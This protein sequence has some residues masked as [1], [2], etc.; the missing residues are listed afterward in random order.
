MKNYL[1]LAFVLMFAVIL[2]I[3]FLVTGTIANIVFYF[4]DLDKKGSP[5]R[6]CI[7]ACK[8]LIFEKDGEP[9]DIDISRGPCLLNPINE[10]PDWVCDVANSPRQDVDYDPENQCSSYNEGTATH[11][12]E[13]T[14][15][16][17]LIRTG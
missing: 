1:L 9:K 17:E 5:E 10:Y 8:N 2:L 6:V 4:E 13:I 14:P 3:V 11:F 12:V 7:T 16:C 15:E